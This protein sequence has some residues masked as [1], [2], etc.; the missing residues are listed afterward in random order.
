MLNLKDILNKI[1][2]KERK[3]LERD[4][5]SLI[6]IGKCRIKLDYLDSEC[7]MLRVQAPMFEYRVSV[8]TPNSKKEFEKIV[9]NYLMENSL[10][11]QDARHRKRGFILSFSPQ[12]TGILYNA[13]K[14]KEIW[15][16]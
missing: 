5:T 7:S 6:E 12:I 3:A 16:D 15:E 2:R 9:E 13:G 1:Y 14:E 10:C 11:L 8:P 4:S